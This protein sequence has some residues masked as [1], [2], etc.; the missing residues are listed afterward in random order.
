MHDSIYPMEFLYDGECRLCLNDVAHLRRLDKAGRLIFIDAAAADF[1][2]ALYGG[3]QAA[4]LARIHARLADGRMVSGMEVFRLALAA[5]GY[6][7]LVEP[8]RWPG[9]RQV[10]ELAYNGFAR[11]RVALS[12]RFGGLFERH[13]PVC[14]S[15]RCQR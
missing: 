6:A 5:V 10:S 3:D 13:A 2:A 15:N 11:H 1:D 4:L 7:W 14:D 8:T 9:L 12:R